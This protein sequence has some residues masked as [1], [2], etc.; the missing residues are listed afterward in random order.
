MSCFA[1]HVPAALRGLLD[2]TRVAMGRGL[3]VHVGPLLS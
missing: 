3:A 1:G 2:T